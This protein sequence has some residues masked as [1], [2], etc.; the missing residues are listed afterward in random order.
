MIRFIAVA[1][2]GSITL[3]RGL[4]RLAQITRGLELARQMG[5]ARR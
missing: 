3:F 4:D 5:T 1:S 2:V